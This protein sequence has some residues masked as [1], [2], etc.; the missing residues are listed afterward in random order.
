MFAVCHRRLSQVLAVARSE[1][2]KG[3]AVLLIQLDLNVQLD[4]WWLM[5]QNTV[6]RG[7]VKRASNDGRLHANLG[8]AQIS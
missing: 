4:L 6:G 5:A 7:K 1:T 2:A 8:A 3:D